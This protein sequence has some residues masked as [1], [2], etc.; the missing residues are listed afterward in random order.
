MRG[1]GK[2]KYCEKC[3]IESKFL[4]QETDGK[5]LCNECRGVPE[6]KESKRD[7]LRKMW[8]MDDNVVSHRVRAR[9]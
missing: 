1:K 6:R 8:E 7:Q 5:Y 4:H 2:P 9:R 3:G